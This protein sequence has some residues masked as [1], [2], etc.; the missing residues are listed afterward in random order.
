MLSQKEARYQ[1][2]YRAAPALGPFTPQ[3]LV[4]TFARYTPLQPCVSNPPSPEKI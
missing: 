2:K 3:R 4:Q 1:S